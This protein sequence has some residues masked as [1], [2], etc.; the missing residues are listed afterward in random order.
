MDKK[1]DN[2]KEIVQT[3]L[4]EDDN[5]YD[6]NSYKCRTYIEAKESHKDKATQLKKLERYMQELA[7]DIVDMIQDSSTE[8]KQ[9]LEK[10]ITALATK[11]GS[12]K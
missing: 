1:N 6:G 2:E 4:L 7:T 10:K 12:M 3:Y 11:V 8:E 9:Y 5:P